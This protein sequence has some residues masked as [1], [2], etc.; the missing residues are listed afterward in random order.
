M[1]YKARNEAINFFEDYSSIMSVAKTKA[2]N[3]TGL[4]T[5]TPKQMYQRLQIAHAQVKPGNNSENLL[6][7]IREIIYSLY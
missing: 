2:T 4:K 1:L 6:N 3:R 7:E 5:L